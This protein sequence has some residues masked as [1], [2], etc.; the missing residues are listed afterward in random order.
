MI[1]TSYFA[2]MKAVKA[3]DP[4]AVFVAVCGAVPKWWRTGGDARWVIR[5]APKWKWWSEWRRKFDGRLE[6]EESTG[7]YAERYRETVLAGLDKDEV[8]A[9]LEGMAAPGGNV[10]LLCYE[11]PGRFCHRRL[12]AEWLGGVEEWTGG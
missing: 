10:Y 4:S 2:K 6:S 11:A 1:Y 7:W 5:L 8:R 12:L 9:E 3:A